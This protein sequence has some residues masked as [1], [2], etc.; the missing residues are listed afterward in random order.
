ME[1]GLTHLERT[2]AMGADNE[3]SGPWPFF[4]DG[5]PTTDD[6]SAFGHRQ[7]DHRLRS[8]A[9]CSKRCSAGGR[10]RCWWQR[11]LGVGL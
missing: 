10:Y 8:L 5:R 1:T 6:R 11:V 4:R 2:D 9:V 3:K 7:A